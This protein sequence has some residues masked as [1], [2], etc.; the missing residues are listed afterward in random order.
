MLAIKFRFLL[1]PT[2]EQA[3]NV[4]VDVV[5]VVVIVVVFVLNIE[6]SADKNSPYVSLN[7]ELVTHEVVVV[8][9]KVC[10]VKKSVNIRSS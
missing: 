8:K 6:K 5:Q 10:V 1:L 9:V 4:A 3:F 7:V 2:N